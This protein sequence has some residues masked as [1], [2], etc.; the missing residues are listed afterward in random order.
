[1]TTIK[2]KPLLTTNNPK[3]IKGLKKGYFTHI[4]YLSPFN[5]N[6]KGINICSHAS[7]GCASACL[8][9]SGMGG[10]YTNVQQGR[11]NKTEYFLQ[12]RVEFLNQLVSEI[13]K[14][15]KKHNERG[16]KFC[17][18]LNGTSDIRFEGFKIK[19]NKNI[20]ELF[21][22]VQFY[23]YTK[24]YLRFTKV[25]PSNYD[26]TFSKS[27]TNTDKAFELL[28]SGIKVAMVLSRVV[29]RYKGYKVV[30]G[31][32]NDLTFLHPK[33]VIIGLRYKLM[34]NKGADNKKAFE[35]GFV[36]DVDK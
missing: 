31:D 21:P 13:T 9:N 23:D 15:E 6:S 16:E 25:L 7:V 12:N 1:M 20:F 17:I 35:N 30:N 5:Q 18:R 11:M 14:I 28:N 36:V 26:L 4:L 27:E 22:N 10:I 8:F 24:N 3:T 32:E 2:R 33:K 29:K 34:T 19:D